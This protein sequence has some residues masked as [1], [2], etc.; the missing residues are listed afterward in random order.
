MGN[1]TNMKKI[2]T[3]QVKKIIFTKK[4]Y[5]ELQK[6]YTQLLEDRKYAV[7]QLTKA[8]EMGDL[9]ENGFYKASRAKLS[10]F[11]H[12]ILVAKHQ[13][14]YGI[15]SEVSSHNSIQ[16]G[17]QAIIDDGIKQRTI[18]LVGETEAN[19]LE[20]KISSR[21]PIGKKLLGKKAGEIFLVEV[22]KGTVTYTVIKLL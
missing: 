17:M 11:D 13:I 9:S 10:S 1:F 20:G 22:P 5:E 6:K 14:R 3:K 2:A 16:I 7:Q 12:Q 15:I 21:S 8:R 4:G 19:P 18:T